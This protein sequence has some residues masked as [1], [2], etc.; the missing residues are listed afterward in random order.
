MIWN[1]SMVG[2]AET[3]AC[4]TTAKNVEP[5]YRMHENITIDRRLVVCYV[6]HVR[7]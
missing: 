7:Y 6:G 4:G 5:G 3:D 2:H 1:Y